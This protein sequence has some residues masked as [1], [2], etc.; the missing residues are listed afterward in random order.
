VRAPRT[1]L[2]TSTAIA[3]AAVGAPALAGPA[4]STPVLGALPSVVPS[5]VAS[6]TLLGATPATQ[7]VD[8]TVL[9]AGRD[10]A[11]SQRDP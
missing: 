11:G 8:F 7:R 6:S 10:E 2:W 1:L 3:V 9:V 4:S 5:W